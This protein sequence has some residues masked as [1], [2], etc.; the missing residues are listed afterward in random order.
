MIRLHN[1]I[2]QRLSLLSS[3]TSSCSLLLCPTFLSLNLHSSIQP[4]GSAL[5]TARK[6]LSKT[7]IMTISRFHSLAPVRAVAAEDG[8]GSGGG[9]NGSAGASLIE[10]DESDSIGCNY[11]LPAPEIRDIVDAPPLPALSF[12]PQR[13]KILFLKRRALPPLEELARPEEKLAGIRIDGKYNTRSRI[14]RSFYTGIGIHQLMHDGT[15]GP[16]KE[17]HGFPDG[18]KINFVSW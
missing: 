15:L 17:V 13:D 8:G 5:R 18:A 11:R 6:V 7:H 2:Y 14:H 4:P 12:S 3:S 16:E 10:D 9:S 1:I